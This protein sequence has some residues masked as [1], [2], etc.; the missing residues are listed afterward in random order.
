MGPRRRRRFSR[1]LRHARRGLGEEGKDRGAERAARGNSVP[2]S[3]TLRVGVETQIFKERTAGAR[4]FASSHCILMY[5]ICQAD[6]L[7]I[8]AADIA[9]RCVDA[10][11]GR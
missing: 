9:K 7:G 8:F 3:F 5:S 6:F 1:K 4:P 2:S 10:N 11:L